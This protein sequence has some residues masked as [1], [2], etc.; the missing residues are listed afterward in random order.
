MRIEP[1]IQDCFNRNLFTWGD[2]LPLRW[3]VNNTQRV[4]SGVRNKTG[5]DTGNYV[6]GKIEPKSRKNDAF[7]ALVA[8]MT[9]EHELPNEKNVEIPTIPTFLF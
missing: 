8:S 3:A 6:Y 1:I 4:K 7:M 5:V 9:M 2:N